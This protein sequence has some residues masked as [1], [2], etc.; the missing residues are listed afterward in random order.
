MPRSPNQ[1]LI[2]PFIESLTDFAVFNRR[3]FAHMCSEVEA[4]DLPTPKGEKS[5]L[6]QKKSCVENLDKSDRC[7]AK[8]HLSVNTHMCKSEKGLLK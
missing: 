1:F 5:G 3:S 2:V 4:G 6:H 8:Y 7:I